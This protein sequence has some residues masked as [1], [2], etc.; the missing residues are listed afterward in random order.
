MSQE[1]LDTVESGEVGHR[2]THCRC[3]KKLR[4]ESGAMGP[5]GVTGG[6]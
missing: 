3:G 4:T 1:A 2:R 6:T 5:E